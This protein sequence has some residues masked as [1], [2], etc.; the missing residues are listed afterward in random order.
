MV[1]DETEVNCL[2]CGS[3]LLEGRL[4]RCP[5][6]DTAHH[7]ECWEYNGGC[8]TYACLGGRGAKAVA[9]KRLKVR[10]PGAPGR[11]PASVTV[12]WAA[13]G[14][15]LLLAGLMHQS[16]R[17][18]ARQAALL[19]EPDGP[20]TLRF[21]TEVQR[22]PQVQK[23]KPGWVVE[24]QGAP[25]PD[26][27][28]GPL[29]DSEPFVLISEVDAPTGRQALLQGIESSTGQ[30]LWRHEVPGP[31]RPVRN[32]PALAVAAVVRD[33]IGLLSLTGGVRVLDRRTG[34]LLRAELATSHLRG[35]SVLGVDHRQVS[36]GG[37]ELVCEFGPDSDTS[38][39]ARRTGEIS[40]VQCSLSGDEVVVG[41]GRGQAIA[42]DPE[43]RLVSLI[44]LHSSRPLWESRISERVHTGL[45]R[46]NYIFAGG[47]YLWVWDRSTGRLLDQLDFGSTIRR[48]DERASFLYV[49]HGTDQLSVLALDSR[50]PLFT[51]R[52]ALQFQYVLPYDVICD[53]EGQVRVLLPGTGTVVAGLQLTEDGQRAVRPWFETWRPYP[54][55]SS[56]T[57][58]SLRQG[59]LFVTLARRGAG[60]FGL[61]CFPFAYAR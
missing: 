30:I 20:R 55:R 10:Q 49:L 46:M 44:D 38:A 6:C 53:R 21:P 27:I 56:G 40:M 59:R 1:P 42:Q 28:G 19:A 4:V 61:A 3:S 47:R 13:F 41:A 17:G 18:P 2:V 8:A 52:G 12:G 57:R 31:D 48:I 37:P 9:G 45:V 14:A 51:T 5:A 7:E 32:E 58:L 50:R 34:D 16:D 39:V 29:D 33:R 54:Y 43:S 11:W 23:L 25:R 24:Q 35:L 60:T 22:R 26:W 15:L 36:L